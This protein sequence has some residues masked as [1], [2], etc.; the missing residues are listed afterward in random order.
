MFNLN[1]KILAINNLFS[2]IVAIV[3]LVPMVVTR[4]WIIEIIYIG[5]FGLCN[6]KMIDLFEIN[7]NFQ[8]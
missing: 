2:F 6:S 1:I 7:C 8:N 4:T 3:T 5:T